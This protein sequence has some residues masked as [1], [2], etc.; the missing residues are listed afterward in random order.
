[1]GRRF[2]LFRRT[3]RP[4]YFAQIKNPETG[5]YT[6]PKSTG[7]AEESE[8]LLVVAEW[9]RGGIPETRT[10][11][12][13]KPAEV[14]TVD[15]IVTAIR[16]AEALT[17][18][19]VGRIVRALTDRGALESARLPS[20]GP[21]TEGLLTF[22]RRFW[23]YDSSPYVR[24][25]LAYGHSIGRRHCR[26]QALRLSHWHGYFADD[27][28]RDVT[29][30]Q[31]KDFSLW[32]REKELAAK[33][34]NAVLSAGTVALA[35]ATEQGILETNPAAGLRKFSGT[36]AKRGILSV[37]EAHAVFSMQ[38]AD[39]RARV[40]N[41]VAMTCGLRA[42]EVLALRRDDIGAD[43]LYIR[44]SYSFADGLKAPK[45]GEARET[46]LL[47]AVRDEL[48]SLLSE[49]PYTGNVFLFYGPEPDTPMSANILRRGLHRTLIDMSLSETD[50]G[51]EEKRSAEH[52]KILDRGIAVHSWRHFYAVHMADRVELRAVQLATGHKSADMAEH[53]ANHKQAEHWTAASDAAQQA[54]GNVIPF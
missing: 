41:L 22:L 10:R 9:L 29:H 37:N 47:P 16:G 54:F 34:C 51:N 20:E 43:R 17:E 12:R 40:G 28:L 39:T 42:G 7:K 2:S 26:E 25:K 8:A 19:D 5:R 48:L 36:S 6:P 3:N 18:T 15:S 11:T 46:P 4:Y 24:E 33:T 31:L 52:R 38:W 1:M 32:L 21:D 14:F 53:Y 44:H 50:R 35:W 27:A 49:N 23:D 45:N 30:D 13:R